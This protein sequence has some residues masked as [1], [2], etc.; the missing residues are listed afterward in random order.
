VCRSRKTPPGVAAAPL[1]IDEV[2]WL[3][4]RCGGRPWRV[5]ERHWEVVDSA[6]HVVL[7]VETPN[8]RELARFLAASPLIVERLL[9]ET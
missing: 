3:L 4:A 5:G 2:R 1:D 7:R 8:A 9:P 6:G